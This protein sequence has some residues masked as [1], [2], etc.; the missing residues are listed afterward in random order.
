ML[1]DLHTRTLMQMKK[2]HERKVA[3][4]EEKFAALL[5]QKKLSE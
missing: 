3:G 4:D 1:E 2:E 5:E